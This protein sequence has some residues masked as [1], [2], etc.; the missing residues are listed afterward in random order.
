MKRTKYKQIV[1]YEVS[2]VKSCASVWLSQRV[3]GVGK[4]NRK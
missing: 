2:M 4:V 1:M 3:R